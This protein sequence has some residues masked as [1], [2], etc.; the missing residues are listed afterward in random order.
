MSAAGPWLAKLFYY[1]AR[2]PALFVE[3]ADGAIRR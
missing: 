3:K 2:L 1:D